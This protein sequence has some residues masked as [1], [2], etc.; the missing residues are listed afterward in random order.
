[1]WMAAAGAK[2]HDSTQIVRPTKPPTGFPAIYTTSEKHT[3]STSK[4]ELETLF[5]QKGTELNK[6]WLCYCALIDAEF[7]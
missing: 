2:F 1:M 5:P 7:K 6:T 4:I 3:E